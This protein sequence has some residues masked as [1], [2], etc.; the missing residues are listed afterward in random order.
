MRATAPHRLRRKL[1]GVLVVPVVFCAGAL[2]AALGDPSLSAPAVAAV[3]A[4]GVVAGGA[5]PAVASPAAS[6]AGQSPSPARALQQATAAATA[7]G[8]EVR[9]VVLARD[10]R[11]LLTGPDATQ[12]IYTASLVKLLVVQQLLRRAESGQVVL[13]APHR[14]LLRRAVEASDDH[15]MNALWVT[16]DGPALV[17]AAAAEFGLSGTAPT[18]VAGQW[19]QSTTTAVDYANFLVHL[20]AHLTSDDAATLTG[21]MRSTTATAADGFDQRFGVL[22]PGSTRSAAIGAK[23]GWM[24]CVAGRRQLHSAGVLADGRVVVV[25]GDFPSATGWPAAAAALD[26][27]AAAA[28]SGTS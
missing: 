27:A 21:W 7:A 12:P 23:Q 15:A 13:D 10:G 26:A 6:V 19:G 18:A 2:A 17:A 5:G 22:G 20:P 16:F 1:L 14:D 25:L 4:G 24:C 9:V 28:I 3:P 11:P 8:G